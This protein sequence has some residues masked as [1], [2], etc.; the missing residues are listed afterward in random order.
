[1][2][3]L[4]RHALAVAVL[5]VLSGCAG[6][7]PKLAGV[8]STTAPPPVATVE[9]GSVSGL[10]VSEEELPLSGVD[11]VLQD[12]KNITKTDTSGAFVFN[13][14]E[15][16]TYTLLVSGL[17]YES[18]A[19]TVDVL[20]GEVATV[21]VELK[22]LVLKPE[23][24][25]VMTPF[26]GMVQCA[27]NPEYSIQPCGNVAAEDKDQF[28]ITTEPTMPLE[29]LVLELVWTPTMAG[30]GASMELS[31]CDAHPD[32]QADVLCFENN[33]Y[34]Y[35]TTPSPNVMRLDGVPIDTYN[36]WLVAAGSG[37]QEPTIAFQQRFTV[38]VTLCMVESC[39]EDYSAVPTA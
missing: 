4:A 22:V 12:M 26:E 1:M 21:R 9:T 30:T 31:F 20:A 6:A 3:F 7:D 23:P 39:P 18:A 32:R 38:Y 29:E 11:V 15:P 16:R 14:L 33:F 25:V 37:Y 24:Y 2:Q 27:F 34:E 35:Q 19:R 36:E 8:A 10:I 17:G 5:V 28:L 13:G